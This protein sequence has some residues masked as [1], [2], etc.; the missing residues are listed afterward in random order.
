MSAGINRAAGNFLPKKLRS[1]GANMTRS[2]DAVVANNDINYVLS[3]NPGGIPNNLIS[4][5]AT[6]THQNQKS[7]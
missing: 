2:Q 3:P 6:A 5:N 7:M 1:R 4:K